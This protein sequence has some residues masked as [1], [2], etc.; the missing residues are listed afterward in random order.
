MTHDPAL[1]RDRLGRLEENLRLIESLS[2]L[3]LVEFQGDP[4]NQ[5]TVLHALQWA[6]EACLEIGNH[7]AV[8]DGLGVPADYAEIFM[9]LRDRG[10]IPRELGEQ[11]V[12]MARFRNRIVHLYWKMDWEDV[13][14]IYHERLP[15]LWAFKRHME[16][17]LLGAGNV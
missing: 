7:I 9:V 5:Y 1:I 3:S 2:S 6:I 10:V 15:D 11:L 13:Y 8:A 12:K 17:Y 14:R 16:Q 4:R